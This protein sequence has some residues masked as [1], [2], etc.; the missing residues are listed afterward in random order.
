MFSKVDLRSGYHQVASM[1]RIFSRLF[2]TRY[3]H[4]DFVVVPFSVTNAPTTFMCLMNIVLHPYLEK[5]V[6]VFV[7]DILVYSKNEE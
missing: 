6:I 5:F 3:G 7:D 1:K 2:R 4:Y